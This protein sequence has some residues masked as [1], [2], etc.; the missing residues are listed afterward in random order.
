MDRI[1]HRDCI[2]CSAFFSRIGHDTIST[3]SCKRRRTV[4][5]HHESSLDNLQR[6]K[7]VSLELRLIRFQDIFPRKTVEIFYKCDHVSPNKQTNKDRFTPVGTLEDANLVGNVHGLGLSAHAHKSLLEA[8]GRN[9][10]VNLRTLDVVQLVDGIANLPLVGTDVN[11]ESEDV[12]RLHSKHYQIETS[13]FFI[14]DSLTAG[15][16]MMA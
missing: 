6:Y 4:K 1:L 8:E 2:H 16:L 14:E 13:I 11:E 12:L 5:Y 3:T 15:F 7:S 9:H 10:S